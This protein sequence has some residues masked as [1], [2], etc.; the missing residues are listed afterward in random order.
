MRPIIK[1]LFLLLLTVTICVT[2]CKKSTST[3]FTPSFIVGYWSIV[4]LREQLYVDGI[5]KYDTTSTFPSGNEVLN[6]NSAGYYSFI[7]PHSTSGGIYTLTGTSLTVLDTFASHLVSSTFIV[8]T[9]TDHALALQFN[10]TLGHAP[11]DTVQVN[12]IGYTR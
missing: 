9:L 1:I 5:V 3:P 11:A 2:G 8:S 12:T 4:S 6:F 10:D 7:Y